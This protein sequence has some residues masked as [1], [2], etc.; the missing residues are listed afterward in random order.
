MVSQFA[1]DK[2]IATKSVVTERIQYVS[3]NIQLY[4]KRI[5]FRNFEK[6]RYDY[7]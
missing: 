6:E 1:C 5:I 7:E 4:M 2:R 3:K